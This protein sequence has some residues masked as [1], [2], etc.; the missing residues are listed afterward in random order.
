[1]PKTK[2][3]EYYN[4]QF[5]GLLAILKKNNKEAGQLRSS[6]EGAVGA[7]E[8]GVRCLVRQFETVNGTD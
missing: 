6:Y 5:D 3:Q 2:V 4:Q 7:A 8:A 1:M